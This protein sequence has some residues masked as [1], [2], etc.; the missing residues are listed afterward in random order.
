MKSGEAEDRIDL[1]AREGT[2]LIGGNGQEGSLYLFPEGA[3]RRN[4]TLDNAQAHVMLDGENGEVRLKSQNGRD[5]IVLTP[6]SASMGIGGNG[7]AGRVDLFPTGAND[8]DDPAQAHISLDGLTG[9]ATLSGRHGNQRIRLI[10]DGAD[11][12]VGGDGE[13]GHIYV[14]PSSGNLRTASEATIHLDGDAGDIVLSN[15]DCAED[16]PVDE[17]DV[18]EPGTVVVIKDDERLGQCKEA[19]DKRVAGVISGA[20]GNKPAIVLGKKQSPARRM[21]LALTG[22]VFCKVDA[23]YAPIDVGDILTTSLTPG[24]AMRALDHQ[25]AAGA[26]VGK[27]LRPLARG[28]GLI[29]ILVALQ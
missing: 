3:D 18:I 21:P 27:A 24:H 2:V 22:K 17:S 10:P 20:C 1:Y 9:A 23:D 16:F 5:R 7:H 11:I 15:G 14:Y 6:N 13:G 8:I 28:Q 19:Y 12:R 4:Q 25:K 29:P 26:S